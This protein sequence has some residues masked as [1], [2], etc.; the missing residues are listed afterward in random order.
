M[1]LGLRIS[2]KRGDDLRGKSFTEH[3]GVTVRPCVI[4]NGPAIAGSFKHSGEGEIRQA[5]IEADLVG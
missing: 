5:S 4:A 2:V 1:R 3:N